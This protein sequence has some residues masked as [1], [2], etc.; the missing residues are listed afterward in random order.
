MDFF[1]GC[2][3]IQGPRARLFLSSPPILCPEDST[4]N[5]LHSHNSKG[6]YLVSGKQRQ[7]MRLSYDQLVLEAM[8]LTGLFYTRCSGNTPQEL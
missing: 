3:K 8:A 1:P 4:Q 5:L 2:I 6:R 7:T